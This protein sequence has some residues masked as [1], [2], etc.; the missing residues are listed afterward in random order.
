MLL[1]VRTP[2]SGIVSMT[3]CMMDDEQVTIPE[4]IVNGPE[5]VLPRNSMFKLR[6]AMLESGHGIRRAIL[7]Y[8]TTFRLQ[9]LWSG[10]GALPMPQNNHRGQPRP[11][12]AVKSGQS[13]RPAPLHGR[14]IE[15]LPISRG[16]RIPITILSP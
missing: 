13:R 2:T 9:R 1:V 5:S 16:I 6:T 7:P 8:K 10:I 14:D 4:G 3:R 15:A 11:G 12:Q